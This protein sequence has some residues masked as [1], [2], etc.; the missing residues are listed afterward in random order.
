MGAPRPHPTPPPGQSGAA[1]GFPGRGLR[2]CELKACAA[3]GGSGGLSG[4]LLGV[5]AM[6]GTS[7][8][9]GWPAAGGAWPQLRT[10]S[11]QCP[12]GTGSCSS[13][14]AQ[15]SDA[16]LTQLL[17]AFPG[18][19]ELSIQGLHCLTG[20]S[21]A[22]L[23]AQLHRVSVTCA[24]VE[25]DAAAHFTAALATCGGRRAASSVELRLPAGAHHAVDELAGALHEELPWAA[26]AV[27]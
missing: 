27:V 25:P 10:L 26:V 7:W 14:H 20:A 3:F 24:S 23:A 13:T 8:P 21:L 1:N 12:R 9:G 11:L 15:V 19:C 4:S 16:L 5:A 6:D 22:R 18:L 17:S 2:H